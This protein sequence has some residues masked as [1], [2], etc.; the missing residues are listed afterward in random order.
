MKKS[1]EPIVVEQVLNASMD[2]VWKSITE[3]DLMRQ[4]YFDNIPSFRPEAGFETQFTIEHEGRVFPHKWKVTGVVPGRKIVY[5]WR[6]DGYA[7][8][9]YVAFEL[10]EQGGSTKLRLTA[11]VTE[12][13]PE[14][15]PELTRESCI[16]G[17]EYFIQQSLKAFVEK[18]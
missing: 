1:D 13:F 16:G 11:I 3:I 2:T 14:G 7:G 5:T 9:S 6:F 18:Q 4:W 8:D 15:I 17:W 10:S 12:D